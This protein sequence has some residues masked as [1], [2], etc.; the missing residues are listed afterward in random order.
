MIE[1]LIGIS[2]LFGIVGILYILGLVPNLWSNIIIDYKS[3]DS[4]L[5]R[6]LSNLIF[7]LLCL[8]IGKLLYELGS[9]IMNF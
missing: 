5:L 2:V 4:I 9:L 8:L 3:V 1:I 7:I 6:G